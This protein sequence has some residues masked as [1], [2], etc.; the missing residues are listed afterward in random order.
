MQNLHPN[1]FMSAMLI[2]TIDLKP[3]IVQDLLAI[4][5]MIRRGEPKM[6][7]PLK[8]T[9]EV[10]RDEDSLESPSKVPCIAGHSFMRR[11]Q[12][13]SQDRQEAKNLAS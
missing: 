11:L 5:N 1:S 10:D 4:N 2:S 12:D 3:E 13:F 9:L 6:M 7:T 8:R